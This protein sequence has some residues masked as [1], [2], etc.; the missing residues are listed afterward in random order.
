M[1]VEGDEQPGLCENIHRYKQSVRN[2]HQY[3]LFAKANK[4]SIEEKTKSFSTSN[5]KR[6]FFDDKRTGGESLDTHQAGGSGGGTRK[7]T[8][9]DNMENLFQNLIK[10]LVNGTMAT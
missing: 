1:Q 3:L 10:L 7:L 8:Q 9:I 5:P 2:T 4:L 6:T